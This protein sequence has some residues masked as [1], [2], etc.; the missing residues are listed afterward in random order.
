MSVLYKTEKIPALDGLR[1]L[2]I[3]LVFLRHNFYYFSIYA[4]EKP[5]G[6]FISSHLYFALNGWIGVDLF[7]VLSGFLIAR[8]FISGQEFSLKIYA[9]KRVLRIVPAYY[10]VLFLCVVGFFPGYHIA[11]QG[12][13]LNLSILRHMLFMHDYFPADINVVF[14][15]LGVE[16]K[17]YIV[18]PFIVFFL[19]KYY[20]RKPSAFGLLLCALLLFAIVLRGASYAASGFTTDYSQFFL[21]TRSPFHCCLDAFLIGIFVAFSERYAKERNI[22]PGKTMKTVLIFGAGILFLYCISNEFMAQITL[23]DALAQPF[24]LAVLMGVLVFSG[25]HGVLPRLFS[26]FSLRFISKISY[27]FY[28]VHLPLWPMAYLL[29]LS[30]V[31]EASTLSIIATFTVINLSICLLFSCLLY[32]VVERPFLKLKDKL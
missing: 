20:K 2:A 24:I 16:E 10:C 13:D 7:F 32:Y 31:G 29:T 17:F 27:S 6:D 26:H 21:T 28:L 18:A 15:S 30:I 25:V 14:W 12:H 5:Y 19:L 1:A 23:F 8:P 9:L 22:K 4:T 3:L 11:A